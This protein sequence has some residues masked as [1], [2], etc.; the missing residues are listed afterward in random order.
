MTHLFHNAFFPVLALVLGVGLPMTATGCTNTRAHIR[1]DAT[2]D[3]NAAGAGA[4]GAPVYV[5]IR[6]VTADA[7]ATDDYAA[8]EALASQALT[9]K[10]PEGM[11]SPPVRVVPGE[12]LWLHVKLPAGQSWAVYALYTDARDD[13]SWKQLMTPAK[14]TRVELGREAILR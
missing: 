3:A 6:A 8:I 10:L 9:G 4:A 1:I 11:P 2:Q 12:R 7:F 5:M 14:I 13:G